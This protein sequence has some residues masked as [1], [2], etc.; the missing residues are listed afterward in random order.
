M[1]NSYIYK[2]ISYIHV[3]RY[4]KYRD[5]EN[6]HTLA[7][8]GFQPR[9]EG[10][11]A[12]FRVVAREDGCIPVLEVR[13]R[14]A[15]SQAPA[16]WKVHQRFREY[17]GGPTGHKERSRWRRRVTGGQQEKDS[18][19]QNR[20]GR[21]IQQEGSGGQA[22]CNPEEAS[23]VATTMSMVTAR[24]PVYGGFFYLE[25]TIFLEGNEEDR[26]VEPY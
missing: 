18:R 26:Y 8:R 17:H 12:G 20:R 22:C 1:R 10:K 21:S 11:V 23:A 14:V 16:W 6:P 4:S 15:S 25:D 9:Q 13:E 5:E 2:E 24:R 3:D 19:P 7:Q